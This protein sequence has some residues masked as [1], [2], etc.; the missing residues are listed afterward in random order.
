MRVPAANIADVAL[1]VL[2]VD[3]VEAYDGGV[4]ADV[5]FGDVRRG[6]E[7]G[8]RGGG[9][10]GFEAVEGCEEGGYVVG[11]GFFGAVDG[12]SAS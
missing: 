11:V 6:E 7:V 4:E 10:V 1:E 12:K 3:G 8:C 9:E 5:C 2:H